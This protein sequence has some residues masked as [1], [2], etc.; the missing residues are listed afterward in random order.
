MSNATQR[1]A[2]VTGG[3]NGIGDAI[4]AGLAETGVKVFSLDRAEPKQ[5]RD[6]VVYL[7]ADVSDPEQV[8]GVFARIDEA[9]QGIDIVVHSAGIQR[10]GLVGQLSFKDW[11]DVIGTHLTGMFLVASE[12]MPR[13]IKQ[14]RGGAIISIASTAAF[15][16]LPGR[17]PYTAAKAGI[18]GLTRSLAVEAAPYRI[19]VNA[20]APGFT[21]TAIIEDAI[22]NGSLQEDWM[23]ERVPMRRLAEPAEIA[24]V[25]RF[26]ASDDSA[27]VTGQTIVADGGWTIQ[28]INKSPDWLNA[29]DGQ[30]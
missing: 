12:A 21:R 2:L 22:A 3:A 19:R 1:I 30:K 23:L 10:S 25:V 7:D 6:G 5:L 14:G 4:I 18:A 20:V 26:L 15:V 8:A 17:G 13:M 16:G 11:S 29:R 27:Y 24:K 28:G 9:G